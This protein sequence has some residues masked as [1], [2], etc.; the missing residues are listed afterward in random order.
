M[1]RKKKNVKKQCHLCFKKFEV[2]STSQ[3]KFCSE[4]CKKEHE[5]IVKRGGKDSE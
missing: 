3:A 5:R 2:M 1:E 4:L